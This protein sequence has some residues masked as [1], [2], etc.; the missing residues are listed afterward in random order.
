MASNNIDIRA[1]LAALA[2]QQGQPDISGLSNAPAQMPITSEGF[3]P[4]PQ[5]QIGA[6]EQQATSNPI[7]KALGFV[8][9]S[10]TGQPGPQGENTALHV[11]RSL[12][13]LGAAAGIGA[14]AGQGTRGLGAGGGALS[15]LGG[16][17]QGRVE[18]QRYKQ[19]LEL[20][21][22]KQQQELSN[23][24]LQ[25]FLET[26]RVEQTTRANDIRQQRANQ[27]TTTRN[28]DRLSPEGIAAETELQKLLESV[29]NK[30]VPQGMMEMNAWLAKPENAGKDASDYAIAM[31]KV[32]PETS[33]AL[34]APAA[35]QARMDRSYNL[36][37]TQLDKL[38]VPIDALSGRLGRLEDSIAENSPQADALV[39]PEL[40]TVMAG[41]QGSGLR[42][43]E[44][45]IARI[46]GGRSN[47]ETF[48]AAVNKW[49][50]D[51]E[52]A[53]TITTTQRQQIRNLTKTVA[54]KIRAKQMILVEARQA[55]IDSEDPKEH[56]R[57]YA[58]TQSR[59]AAI[60]RGES[61]VTAP[62]QY[63][64]TATGPNGEKVGSNDGKTWQPIK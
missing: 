45:E 31:K 58:D 18:G 11:L 50:L 6:N 19:Q 52:A 7:L 27:P 64:Y 9:S 47:W 25:R 61:S 10:L 46:I 28:I 24:Q 59:L 51:P 56:K 29:K 21:K 17:T 38:Q 53:L 15:A 4:T 60:D 5:V 14:W 37:S 34:G 49:S 2:A 41:G 33:A 43:N 32:G 62:Q 36:H 44:A 30:N 57:I 48:K 3:N 54:D 13:P 55:L 1:L 22:Q 26:M 42:M 20:A 39:A 63:K 8:G 16:Y 23:Q 35:Q 12:I 40:L